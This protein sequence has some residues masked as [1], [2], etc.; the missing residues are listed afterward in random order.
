MKK[1]L[2]IAVLTFILPFTLIFNAQSEATDDTIDDYE[3]TSGPSDGNIVDSALTADTIFGIH[4]AYAEAPCEE[5]PCELP[6]I[7]EDHF[8]FLMSEFSDDIQDMLLDLPEEAQKE[9]V[10][11]YVAFAVFVQ[12][13]VADGRGQGLVKG[14]YGNTGGECVGWAELVKKHID[15]FDSEYWKGTG[16]KRGKGQWARLLSISWDPRDKDFLTGEHHAGGIIYSDDEDINFVFDGW[17]DDIY[18]WEIQA[19]EDWGAP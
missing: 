12:K 13:E 2:Y 18:P 6:D 3:P 14:T 1:I 19:A 16:F 8:E 4:S 5:P 10:Q 15:N 7:N 11:L 17:G 9:F